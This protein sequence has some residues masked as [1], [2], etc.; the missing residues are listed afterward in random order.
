MR[1]KAYVFLIMYLLL[2]LQTCQK[3]DSKNAGQEVS[4]IVLTSD[5][6][7]LLIIEQLPLG[8]SYSDVQQIFPD[9][10]EL[11]PDHAFTNLNQAK[12]GIVIMDHQ[13]TIEFNCKFD[14]VYSYYF[15]IHDLDKKSADS[16]YYYL[17]S[18]YTD[19][20]GDFTEER[21]RESLGYSSMSSY[22]TAPQYD[23]VVSCSIYPH[24]CS[25]SWG[26]QKQ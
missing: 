7:K 1:T 9:L 19:I 10:S 4:K 15:A 18:F 21:E 25:L 12:T 17:Q 3:K 14:R 16:L 23:L 5:R 2:A 22:W 11:E 13:A 6:D 20:Y 24:N 8:S 26:F